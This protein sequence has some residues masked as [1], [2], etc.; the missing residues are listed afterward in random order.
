MKRVK[1]IERRFGTSEIEISQNIAKVL[2]SSI[3]FFPARSEMGVDEA[4]RGS[5]E[6]KRDAHRS[7]VA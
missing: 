2:I 4:K 1:E 6:K 5:V 3:A 7:F